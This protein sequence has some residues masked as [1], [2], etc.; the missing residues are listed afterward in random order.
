MRLLS[1]CRDDEG[2]LSPEKVGEV[3][4]TLR[5]KP[6]RNHR[7]ILHYLSFLA[8]REIA[9]STAR[10]TSGAPLSA[11]SVEQIRSQ[12]SSKYGRSIAVDSHRDSA[13][14]AGT[15]VQVG[16]DVFEISI[17]SRLAAIESSGL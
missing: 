17:P 3:L 5:A 14:I 4:A 12:F 1:L 13:M 8:E 7:E 16:D 11:E 15:R 2:R 6:P 9:A 10:V